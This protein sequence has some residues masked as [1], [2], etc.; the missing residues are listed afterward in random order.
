MNILITGG[1]GTIG[2]C[3]SSYLV[4]EGH[5][6]VIYDNQEIGNKKNLKFYLSNNEIKKIKI[7]KGDILNFKKLMTLIKNSDYVYN[8]AATLGTLRV[9]KYPS[10]ML[11]VNSLATHK[12]IDYCVKIKKPLVLF[13][14]SM[15]YGKNPKVSVNEEDNLFVGGNTKIGLWWYAISKLSEEAYANAKIKE[16]PSSKILIIRPFNVIA[17]V[18]NPTV[19]FVFPRFFTSSMKNDPILVYGNGQQR[20]TFTW[21]EDCAKCLVKLINK[22]NYWR[23]TINIGGTDSISIIALAKKIKNITKSKSKIKFVNPK[24]FY[25]NH[26]VEIPK[27]APDV[28]KL[29]KIIG[30]VPKTSLDNMIKKFYK[31][32]KKKN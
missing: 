31:F 9:V 5:K 30:Y 28:N 20:R 25:G 26:F 3:L 12:I 24:K 21:A 2:S 23:N 13:S 29:K 22:K 8:L 14:T 6:I 17:P 19:G 11:N 32:Y 4:K 16:N 18:Q 10:K 15:V 7:I 27:R 1:L